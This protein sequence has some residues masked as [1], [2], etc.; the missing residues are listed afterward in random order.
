MSSILLHLISGTTA[1]VIHQSLKVTGDYRCSNLTTSTANVVIHQLN[2]LETSRF[3]FLK[4]FCHTS[5]KHLKCNFQRSDNTT[6][7]SMLEYALSTKSFYF[8]TSFDITHT[9]QRLASTDE[10]FLSEPLSS[11]ADNRY[12]HSFIYSLFFDFICFAH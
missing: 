10:E 12:Q 8:A 2:F 6:Y 4:S 1:V 9:M 11:R 5:S 7:L 3:L